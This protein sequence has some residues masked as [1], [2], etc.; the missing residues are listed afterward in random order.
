MTESQDPLCRSGFR[1]FYPEFYP[2]L[3][4]L[5]GTNGA[6]KIPVNFP[7]AL[8]CVARW[9]AVLT[10]HQLRGV[11]AT[12]F[13]IGAPTLRLGL[14]IPPLHE[15]FDRRSHVV[16]DSPPPD[17]VISAHTKRSNTGTASARVPPALGAANT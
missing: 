1:V 8:E 4:T 10:S 15:L 14:P 11:I 12:M 17:R 9:D 2:V 13:Q 7:P 16:R 3:M 5:G 6:I